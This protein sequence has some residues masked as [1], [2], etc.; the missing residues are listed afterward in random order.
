MAEAEL[1]SARQD[2]RGAI[3]AAWL[4]G[5]MTF[6]E[7]GRELG[8]S[9]QRVAELAREGE[10]RGLE[11]GLADEPDQAQQEAMDELVRLYE[12]RYVNVVSEELSVELLVDLL[13]DPE[14]KPLV[15]RA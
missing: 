12:Q 8:M 6:A 2:L 15:L 4:V 9:R 7:I 14:T 3:A 5:E 11:F 10:G 13:Q 1:S